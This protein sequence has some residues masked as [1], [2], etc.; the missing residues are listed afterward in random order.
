MPE[1]A[2]VTERRQ[3]VTHVVCEDGDRALSIARESAARHR[4]L[5]ASSSVEP[6]PTWSFRRGYGG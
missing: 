3:R 1:M 6:D 2:H 4:E 5:K